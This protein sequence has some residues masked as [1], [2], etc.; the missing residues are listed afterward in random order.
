MSEEI[1]ALIFLTAIIAVPLFFFLRFSNH[2]SLKKNVMSWTIVWV[3]T[4]LLAFFAPNFWLYALFLA[5]GL[6][7]Y[8][9]N[10]PILKISL[11]FV[12]LPA[13]PAA[14]ILIPSFG[15]VNYVFHIGHHHVLTLILLLPLLL[16]R[17][18]GIKTNKSI[19]ILI[20]SYFFV[21][22]WHIISGFRRHRSYAKWFYKSDYYADT[23]LC[24]Q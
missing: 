8:T 7:Y 21:N 16:N 4:T 3:L 9:R 19:N 11:F 6:Y 23:I 13:V 10:K 1:R 5:F 22:S 20:F 24:D 12:L 15:L 2:I 18:R 17:T 14:T